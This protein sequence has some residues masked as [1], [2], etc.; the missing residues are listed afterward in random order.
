[1]T[2]VIGRELVYSRRYDANQVI[3]ERNG[4]YIDIMLGKK[5]KNPSDLVFFFE[6]DSEQPKHTLCTPK[7]PYV[8]SQPRK[9]DSGAAV[10]LV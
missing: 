6:S 10:T 8:N 5:L 1:M 2:S 9:I 3:V 7:G 4:P